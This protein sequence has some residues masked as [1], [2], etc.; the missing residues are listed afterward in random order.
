MHEKIFGLVGYPLEHSLSPQIFKN[1]FDTENIKNAIYKLFPIKNIN[2]ILSIIKE[3]EN[4]QGLNI[5]MPYKRSI[6]PFLNHIDEIV[7]N[8][9]SVNTIKIKRHNGN[10]FI[11]GYNTDFAAILDQINILFPNSNINKALILGTG[12][13]ANTAKKALELFTKENN[14]LMASRNPVEKYHISYNEITKALLDDLNLVINATPL[15]M[16]PNIH[17][18]PNFPFHIANKNIVFIDLIYNPKETLFLKLAKKIGAKTVNG[19]LILKTQ[20]LNSW[21]IWNSK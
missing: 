20:A 1:I 21:K 9:G 16:F 4:L 13:A 17:S 11:K 8:T 12:G 14:I 10:T 3:N 2:E 19:Q 18:M 7:K 15:G 6:I 5:T